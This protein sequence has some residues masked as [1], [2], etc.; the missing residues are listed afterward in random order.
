MPKQL[1]WAVIDLDGT[2]VQNPEFYRAYGKKLMETVQKVFQV[3]QNETRTL[4]DDARKKY[5]GAG[6]MLLFERGNAARMAWYRAILE[7]DPGQYLHLDPALVEALTQWDVGKVLLTNA[8]SAQVKRIFSV[9]GLPLHLFAL[10]VAW[11]AD[12][13]PP[14]FSPSWFADLLQRLQVPADTVVVIG[15]NERTDLEQARLLGAKTGFIGKDPRKDADWNAG[16]VTELIS[17]IAKT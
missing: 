6:E 17:Q 16:S 13:Q 2:L 8:P 1:R 14:K 12:T 7:V 9:I 10:C 3:G 11:K 15:D 5:D 4:L